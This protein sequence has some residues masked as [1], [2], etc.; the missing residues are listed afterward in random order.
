M[1][2]RLSRPGSLSADMDAQNRE[3]TGGISS[4]NAARKIVSNVS[5][6]TSSISDIT[7]LR[8]SIAML[9]VLYCFMYAFCATC[10]MHANYIC[11]FPAEVTPG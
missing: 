11:N 9:S 3:E 1:E 5:C 6:S 2:H 10:E 8:C 7:A 4:L